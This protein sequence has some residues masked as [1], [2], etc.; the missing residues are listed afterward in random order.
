MDVVH[1]NVMKVPLHSEQENNFIR[2]TS[3]LAFY[4]DDI[5][6]NKTRTMAVLNPLFEYE[7]WQS[8]FTWRQRL[9]KKTQHRA[10]V[11]MFRCYVR[12]KYFTQPLQ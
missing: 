1:T 11:N 5:L 8:V 9:E 3:L 2:G 6:L 4:R 10:A 12:K 7:I